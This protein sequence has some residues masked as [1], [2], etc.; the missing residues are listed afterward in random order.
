MSILEALQFEF[1]RN[2]LLAGALASVSC[3]V[4]GAYVI[5]K[6]LTLISG[7]IAHASLGGIGLAVY[8]GVAPVVG[9]TAFALLS[10]VIIGVVSLYTR[11]HEE[12]LIGAL[13]AVGM[14]LGVVFIQG[15]PGYQ[16]AR[17]VLS[18][19]ANQPAGGQPLHR[20]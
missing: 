4:I 9:A 5:I 16:Q 14:A 8:L 2:A 1:M 15:A 20:R 10:A 3:G 18:A 13:W 6:R 19:D 12:T 17:E 11:E 7:G